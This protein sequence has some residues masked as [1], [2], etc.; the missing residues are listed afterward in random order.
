[1]TMQQLDLL[2]ADYRLLE[3]RSRRARRIRIEVR[4]GAEVWLVI[5]TWASVRQAQTFLN[6]R[7]DWVEQ[8]LAEQRLRQAAQPLDTEAMR[9]D[10][11]DR[12]P[13][14]GVEL[15]VLL[16]PASLRRISL[17]LEDA[18]VRLFCPPEQLAD[19]ARLERALREALKAEALRDARR[20]L[21]EEAARLQV[22]YEGPRIADQRSLW[23]SCAARGLISLSW[24][25]VLAPPEV[26]RYVV[27]HELCHR[28]HHDH[29]EDFWNLV[30]RQMPQYE[31]Q[32]R[33]LRDHGARLHLYMP[34][35]RRG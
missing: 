26:F 25:L 30:A 13:L 16:E 14:R 19:H 32:Y 29:S 12:I 10:G 34:A 2:R 27:I 22:S 7:R 9:W 1:M 4:S 5:P 23:G 6:E 17:R 31:T 3:K 15:P 11:R 33:W 18:A 35:Q 8:K 20:L 28:R 21:A 24:R